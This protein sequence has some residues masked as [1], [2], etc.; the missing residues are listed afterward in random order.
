MHIPQGSLVFGNIWAIMSDP[1]L[2]QDPEV[3]EPGGIWWMLWVGWRWGGAWDTSKATQIQR[4][5]ASFIIVSHSELEGP[6]H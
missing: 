6:R 5:S 4:I 3:F 2:Y 1:G